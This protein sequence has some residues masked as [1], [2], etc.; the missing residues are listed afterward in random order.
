MW[1]GMNPY[2]FSALILNTSRI[3]ILA[4][5]WSNVFWTLLETAIRVSKKSTNRVQTT[6]PIQMM[7]TP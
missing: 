4:L 7:I 2:I 6:S 5:P 1:G 3:Y